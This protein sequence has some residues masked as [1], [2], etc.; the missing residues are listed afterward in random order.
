[1]LTEW[2]QKFNDEMRQTTVNLPGEDGTTMLEEW[3]GIMYYEAA[4]GSFM[5]GLTNSEL[6]ALLVKGHGMIDA[7][8]YW[9]RSRFVD[10]DQTPEENNRTLKKTSL[11]LE[12]Y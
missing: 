4:D 2:E 11:L 7:N 6:R 3:G 1:M 5:T 10:R 8:V 9:H 12:Q